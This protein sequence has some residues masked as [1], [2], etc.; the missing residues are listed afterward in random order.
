VNPM[1]YLFRFLLRLYPA[2]FFREFAEEMTLVFS[3]RQRDVR[4]RGLWVRALYLAREFRGM[5]T[6]ALR[7]QFT[8]VSFRRFDMR[9][10]RFPRATIIVMLVTLV[11][12]GF[13]IERAKRITGGDD[14]R[15][16]WPVLPGMFVGWLVLM[17]ILGLIGYVI[18]RALSQS[19][20]QR[21]SSIETRPQ[22][23]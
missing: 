11:N 12:V 22:R 2:D 18:L 9:S 20:S 1:L 5:V 21:L 3:Q 17:G 16:S 13:A 10:F 23:R 14:T 8:D 19:G 4:H 7:E 15:S 6:G